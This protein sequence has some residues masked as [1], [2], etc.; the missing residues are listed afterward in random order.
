MRLPCLLAVLAITVGGCTAAPRPDLQPGTTPAADS[1]EGGL[2]MVMERAEAQLKTSGKVIPNAALQSYVQDLT[3][4]LAGDHCGQIRTYVVRQPG[5]NASMAP[6]GFMT[7]WSGL[8]L[9][10]ENEDQLVTVLGHEIA[11]YVRRHSVQRWETARD[12]LTAAM[13]FGVMTAGVGVPVGGLAQL[14]VIGHIQAYSRDHEREADR[15]GFELMAKHG[16]DPQAAAQV[17]SNLIAEREAAEADRPDPFFASHPPSEERMES[18]REM[19][20]ALAEVTVQSEAEGRDLRFRNT[21]TPHLEAWLE[22]EVDLG[23]YAQTQ[24]LL[25]RLK[26]RG[27]SQGLAWYYQ[28][29]VLRRNPGSEDRSEAVAAYRQAL[30]HA[31]APVAVHRSLGILLSKDGDVAGARAAFATYLQAAPDAEDREIVQYYLSELETE[32]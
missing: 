1:V 19:A 20:N 28:G 11:H 3:C 27:H 22:D 5:F 6:N 32:S 7:V 14:G 2:W 9:R 26:E 16:Y 29:E 30:N 12:S 17:W 13:V 4:K 25:D 18:L 15:L 21:M 8:L 10:C 24:V 23:R 31:D